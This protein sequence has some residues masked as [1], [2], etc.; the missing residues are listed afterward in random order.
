LFHLFA[1]I[2]PCEKPETDTKMKYGETVSH[3]SS[4]LH[5][6]GMKVLPFARGKAIRTEGIDPTSQEGSMADGKTR[7]I[8]LICEAIKQGQSGA[9]QKLF[10]MVYHELRRMAHGH[11]QREAAGIT[12]Q[13]TSLVHEAYLRLFEGET[14]SWEN[15][16]HFFG[17][18]VMAMRRILVDRARRKKA[19][20]HGGKLVRVPLEDNTPGNARSVDLIALD[21]ALHDLAVELPRHAEVVGYRYFLGMTVKETAELLE[22][23]ERT[24]DSDWKLAKSWLKRR[25]S[26]T[27]TG[28]PSG[29][30]T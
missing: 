20:K 4:S 22:V 30:R 2:Y 8:T 1:L 18:A 26:D 14:A 6:R 24:I 7:E 19:E 16:R 17:A 21:E 3:S 25:I 27:G 28:S 13:T 23:S 10:D 5:R 29:N 9:E 12:L 11:L 15:R